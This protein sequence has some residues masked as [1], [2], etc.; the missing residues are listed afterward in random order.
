MII[1]PD[2]RSRGRRKDLRA[3]SQGEV[4]VDFAIGIASRVNIQISFALA[5]SLEEIRRIRVSSSRNDRPDVSAIR[6]WGGRIDIENDF[7]R[8]MS[9]VR[10]DVNMF[11][12]DRRC[13][14]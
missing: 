7:S 3:L 13:K 4:A 6:L 5:N 9:E 10:I 1:R 14:A 12:G 8:R 2:R 11:A